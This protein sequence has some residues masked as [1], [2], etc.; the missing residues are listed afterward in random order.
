M[1]TFQIEV[2]DD[3]VMPE[4]LEQCAVSGACPRLF[5]SALIEDVL[6][7]ARDEDL[8]VHIPALGPVPTLN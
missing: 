4:L 5:L 3:E 6:I 7:R 1:A 2:D 8:Q